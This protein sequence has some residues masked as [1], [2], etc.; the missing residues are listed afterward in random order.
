M[1]K[2]LVICLAVLLVAAA[3]VYLLVPSSLTMSSIA[4]IHCPDNAAG[5]F[6]SDEN[7]WQSWWPGSKSGSKNELSYTYDNIGFKPLEKAFSGTKLATTINGVTLNG[8]MVHAKSSYDSIVVVWQ[9]G[10]KTSN[11]PFTRVGQYLQ[12][13]KLKGATAAI[14]AH[15][16]DF[17]E[18]RDNVYGL[19]IREI[20]VTDTLL[21]SSFF[22][23]AQPPAM[24]AIYHSIDQL[25]QHIAGNG[26]QETG[27]PMLNVSRI[28]KDHYKT[29]VAIPV[30]KAVPAGGGIEIKKM[31]PGRILVS[32]VK[33]GPAAIE[34]AYAQFR[35]YLLDYDL[36]SP[37]IPFESLVTKRIP[38]KDSAT[39]ITRIYYPIL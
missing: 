2:I 28:D 36:A 15:L 39:W 3:S 32:E 29:R 6:L 9:Y 20:R 35:E 7:K 23:S 25:K 34:K 14:L 30:S 16:K 17:L 5:R 8:T 10:L 21:V 19:A 27:F 18:N 4:Y 1:K 13:K 26:T 33:G 38:V 31:V 12:L 11:N 37:A 24:E 22:E